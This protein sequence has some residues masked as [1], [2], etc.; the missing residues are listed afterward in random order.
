MECTLHLTTATLEVKQGGKMTGNIEHSG[1]TFSSNGVV[2][3][4]HNHGGV[5]HGGDNTD[6][7]AARINL[8]LGSAAT[9]NV[10]DE[11]DELMAVGAF[12]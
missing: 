4:S 12:G 10:G 7:E 1:G 3:D 11:R 9:R 8:Q 5:Q 6:A 2:I